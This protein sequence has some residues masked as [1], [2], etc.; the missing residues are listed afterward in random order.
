MKKKRISKRR[1]LLG[2]EIKKVKKS[3]LI[4]EILRKPKSLRV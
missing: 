3:F 2:S 1:K 4:A